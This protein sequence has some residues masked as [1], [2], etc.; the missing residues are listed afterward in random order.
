MAKK[1]PLKSDYPPRNKKHP[2]GV[3]LDGN[4]HEIEAGKD[5]NVPIKNMRIQVLTYCRN[6]G[7]QVQTRVLEDGKHL[8]L[9]KVGVT[10]ATKVT[11][12]KA[13]VNCQEKNTT[14]V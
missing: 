10:K 13:T 14:N 6:N 5:F 3:W 4:W 11:K 2:W 9:R 1:K 7:I 8:A 12:K